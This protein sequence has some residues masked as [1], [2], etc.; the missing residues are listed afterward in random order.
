MTLAS[1]A[2]SEKKLYITSSDPNQL[3]LYDM[4][5][6]AKYQ[7][8]PDVTASKVIT[9]EIY[10]DCLNGALTLSSSPFNSNFDKDFRD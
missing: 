9:F 10:V 6:S 4:T 8:Y 3:G 1:L 7:D 5:V 2:V